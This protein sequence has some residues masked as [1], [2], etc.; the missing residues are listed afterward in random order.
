[1]YKK[2]YTRL[3]VKAPSPIRPGMKNVHV[4]QPSPLRQPG[5]STN[6]TIFSL[7][8]CTFISDEVHVYRKNPGELIPMRERSQFVIGMSGTPLITDPQVRVVI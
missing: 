4:W 1:M 3:F 2:E 7:L 6:G 5:L 8:P